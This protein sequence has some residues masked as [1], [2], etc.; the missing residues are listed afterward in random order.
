MTP[1]LYLFKPTLIFGQIWTAAVD[2][3]LTPDGIIA[4]GLGDTVS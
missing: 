1:V 3:T 2:P 4:P